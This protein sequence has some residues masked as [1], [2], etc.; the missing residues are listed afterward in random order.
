M[1]RSLELPWTG[2]EIMANI[3]V[4][5]AVRVWKIGVDPA[6]V[7]SWNNYTDNQGY[8]LFCITNGE[9]LTWEKVPLGINLGYKAQGDNKL[10]LGYPMSKSERYS[11]A[12]LSRSGLVAS[13]R[14]SITKKEAQVLTSTGRRSRSTNG[15][16]SART[17]S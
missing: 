14:F 9:Y 8:H 5:E 10:I 12:S 6:N 2:D 11:Q 3:D 13:Q 15:G 1:R 17:V 4:P 16:S 7:L